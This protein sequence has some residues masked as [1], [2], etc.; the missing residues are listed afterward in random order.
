MTRAAQREATRDRIVAAAVEVFASQGFE[1]A[2]TRA[3]AD[4]AGLTQ[5]LLTYH[6]PSKDE[7]WR[8]AAG[9][10]FELVAD[11][12]VAPMR[13]LPEEG[14]PAVGREYLRIYVRFAARHPEVFQFMVDAQTD[15]DGRCEWLVEHHLRPQYQHFAAAMARFDP[16]LSTDDLP[17]VFYTMV[18]AGSLVFGLGEEARRLCGLDVTDPDTVEAH[19]DLVARLLLPEPG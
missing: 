10:I 3:I 9:R 13:A 14:G 4:R 11:E 17:H 16:T 18:G 12:V 5:G 15:P 6:F 19:A 8:A 1:A 7:L 2:G